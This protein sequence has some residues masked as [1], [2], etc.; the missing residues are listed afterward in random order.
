MAVKTG[1]GG[2]YYGEWAKKAGTGGPLCERQVLFATG[3]R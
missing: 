2:D 1:K 3:R